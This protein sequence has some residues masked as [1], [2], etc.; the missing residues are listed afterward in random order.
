M[1]LIF[2]SCFFLSG[3]SFPHQVLLSPRSPPRSPRCWF[4]L[5]L[6]AYFYLTMYNH[7][8]ISKLN[9]YYLFHLFNCKVQEAKD[10]ILVI[11]IL[12]PPSP[13]FGRR[14]RCINVLQT[15]R[16]L[17]KFL[18]AWTHDT[19]GLVYLVHNHIRVA[20]TVLRSLSQR[21]PCINRLLTLSFLLAE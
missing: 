2:C 5:A 21:K 12:P 1:S 19:Q 18:E 20:K 17:Q 8:H 11:L 16:S 15:E 3:K 10:S 7:H 6:W 9:I 4:P 13:E 14:M